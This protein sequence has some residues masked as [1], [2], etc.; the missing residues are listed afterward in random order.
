[1]FSQAETIQ[2]PTFQNRFAME[3]GVC[4]DNGIDNMSRDLAV[5]RALRQPHV[6]TFLLSVEDR[7]IGRVNLYSVLDLK[8]CDSLVVWDSANLDSDKKWLRGQKKMEF[9]DKLPEWLKRLVYIGEF[10]I[11]AEERH[12]GYG[13]KLLSDAKA[14]FSQ[15]H[16]NDDLSF[17]SLSA[18]SAVFQIVRKLGGYFFNPQDYVCMHLDMPA[19]SLSFD[20][21]PPWE[22]Y[23]S[24][25]RRFFIEPEDLSQNQII[26]GL[27][28]KDKKIYYVFMPERTQTHEGD[29][30]LLPD[31]S[32]VLLDP[33]LSLTEIWEIMPAI[34]EDLRRTRSRWIRIIQIKDA[35]R[36][37]IPLGFIHYAYDLN[38]YSGNDIPHLKQTDEVIFTV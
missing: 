10:Y 4:V 5:G 38:D 23:R 27:G 1:M 36:K 31:Q 18:N 3:W 12:K 20:W 9:V 6:K 17:L 14:I 28:K 2:S 24:P 15:I 26:L 13:T 32:L 25:I 22:D 30:I 33:E 37:N 11:K 8:D 21:Q 19:G 34:C 35:V 7:P 29:P 16:P